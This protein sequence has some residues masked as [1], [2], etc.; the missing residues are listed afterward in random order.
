MDRAPSLQKN[1]MLT[2]IAFALAALLFVVAFAVRGAKPA[3]MQLPE[4]VV[5]AKPRIAEPMQFLG[6]GAKLRIEE[7]DQWVS[8]PQKQELVFLRKSVFGLRGCPAT[9]DWLD[10][11]EGQ[12]FA[13]SLASLRGG[14][15]EDAFAALALIF[16]LARATDWKPGVLAHAEHAERIGALLQDWLHAWA[17]RGAKDPLLAE[18]AL[19]AGILYGRV[20]R[21]AWRAPIVGYN[22]APYERA[23]SFL[24][25]LL[26]ERAGHA[27]DYGQAMRDRHARAV[28]RMSS[29]RDVLLGFEEECAALYP[30]LTGE[31]SN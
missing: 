1:V 18:P 28:T 24:A 8:A 25:E 13:R 29:E 7:L 19:A 16:Q 21:T 4:D 2:R 12:R 31:C 23:K 27:S 22:A 17:E 3:P 20:M 26:G 15:R 11:L 14:T 30:D 6:R 10:G 9:S 5:E